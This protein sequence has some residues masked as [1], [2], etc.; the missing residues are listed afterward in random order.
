M[1]AYDLLFFM[2]IALLA[3]SIPSLLAALIDDRPPVVAGLGIVLGGGM[4]VWATLAGG[5]DLN[6][7][8][9]PHLFFE[10]LGRYLP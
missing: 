8:T 4:A 9:L 1:M 3:L 2:G 6:P 10:V 7:A 5:L